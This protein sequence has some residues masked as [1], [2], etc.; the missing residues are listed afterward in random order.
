[1]NPGSYFD[2]REKARLDSSDDLRELRDDDEEGTY[3]IGAIMLNPANGNED[4]Q[5]D[6]ETTGERMVDGDQH[7]DHAA[8]LSQP[9]GRDETTTESGLRTPQFSRQT[10]ATSTAESYAAYGA[11]SADHR[12]STVSIPTSISTI[13]PGG[14]SGQRRGTELAPS[15]TNQSTAS[16]APARWVQ[17]KLFLHQSHAAGA[18]PSTFGDGYYDDEDEAYQ[19]E[20]EDE[21]EPEMNFFNP[22]LLS[23]VSVQ[24]RDRVER[25]RHVKGGIPWPH[26][27]TGRDLVVS[28]RN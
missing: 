3:G 9:N 27:F 14:P 7:D 10:T 17:N 28:P 25:G 5:F 6:D 18:S 26:S 12:Q 23:H 8:Y 1:M 4:H 24:L 21:E 11:S 2:S 19:D 13:D 15:W 20:D 16:R 22:A